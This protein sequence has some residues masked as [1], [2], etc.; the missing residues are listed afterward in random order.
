MRLTTPFN[1]NVFSQAELEI[2][3]N[4]PTGGAMP[5]TTVERF[6]GVNQYVL[7]VQAF[8]RHIRNGTPYPWTL[9]DARGTQAMI[10][11]VFAKAR[12]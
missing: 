11:A 5:T 8:G 12:G 9:E 7:Q 6:P 2:Q 1:A 3:T 4:I 10:D